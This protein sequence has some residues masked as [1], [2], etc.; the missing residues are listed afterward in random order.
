MNVVYVS[1]SKAWTEDL[2]ITDHT[3]HYPQPDDFNKA[4]WKTLP[5]IIRE[6]QV[7]YH[8][9][10]DDL[11]L[12]IFSPSIS[13]KAPVVVYVHGG[14]LLIGGASSYDGHDTVQIGFDSYWYEWDENQVSVGRRGRCCC[15][16]KLSTWSSWYRLFHW[17]RWELVF[18]RCSTRFGS[19][20]LM[21]EQFCAAHVAYTMMF[22]MCLITCPHCV[23]CHNRKT[24][25]WYYLETVSVKWSIN[26]LWSGFNYTYQNL[27][28]TLI[29]WHSWDILLAECLSMR[30]WVHHFRK[31]YFIG[32]LDV[33]SF[34]LERLFQVNFH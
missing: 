12:N 16:N 19:T 7:T 32:K 28:G 6:D 5:R 11:P 23:S 10:N 26:K 30:L 8:T 13:G 1:L 17:K 34:N 9:E 33:P 4:N 29:V 2:P 20:W 31:A 24:V 27:V 22:R 15:L 14:S 18:E 21:F 3:P 25:T